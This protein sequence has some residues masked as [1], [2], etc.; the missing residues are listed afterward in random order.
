MNNLV[1]RAKS[2]RSCLTIT[3]SARTT[4]GR[5]AIVSPGSLDYLLTNANPSE[6][7]FTASYWTG[8]TT[9]PVLSMKPHRSSRNLHRSQAIRKPSG[10]FIT[11]R[12]NHNFP[13]LVD[14]CR[15]AGCRRHPRP[16]LSTRGYKLRCYCEKQSYAQYNPRAE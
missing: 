13:G 2:C 7:L 14:V 10:L 15:L 16:P 11:T 8:M 9:L 1:H 3:D 4:V 6:K 5:N 12:V